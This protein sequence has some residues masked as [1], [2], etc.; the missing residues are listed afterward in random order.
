MNHQSKEFY[1]EVQT[2]K[3]KH[4]N[5]KQLKIHGWIV[6]IIHLIMLY[7]CVFNKVLND[8]R[9]SQRLK[10]RGNE[11]QQI[12]EEQQLKMHSYACAVFEC[13]S[14]RNS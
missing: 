8:W 14:S 12:G 1:S 6:S 2:E 10:S 13:K 9:E 4:T 3:D 5:I 7:K 11:F